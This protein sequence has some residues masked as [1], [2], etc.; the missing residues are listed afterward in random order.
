MS[1]PPIR[2]S[3]WQVDAALLGALAAVTR[4]GDV[5]AVTA[6]LTALYLPWAQEAARHLQSEVAR[7]TYPGGSI[8]AAPR[9]HLP[10]RRL[11]ALCRW[12]AFRSGPAAHRPSPSCRLT[13]DQTHR[14]AA[15][16]SVTATAKPAVTP[17]RDQIVGQQANADFEPCVAA[18]NKSLKGGNALKKLLTDARLAASRPIR[19]TA[20]PRAMPG[21]NTATLT[22]TATT[23]DGN[24][25]TTSRP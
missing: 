23:A 1:P 13:V 14:W 20:I 10:A 19:A 25:P 16:P 12:P 4:P 2:P 15:L 18:T 8:A 22:A 11:P 3:G 7:T 17:V 21:A 5:E 24:W 6:A 9:P